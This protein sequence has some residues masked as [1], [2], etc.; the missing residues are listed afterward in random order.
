MSDRLL[1]EEACPA[2]QSLSW[3]IHAQAFA[4]EGMQ[5]WLDF[6][7]PYSVT[8]NIALARQK[9]YVLFESLPQGTDPVYVLELGAGPGFF[10]WHFLQAWQ[11]LAPDRPIHYLLTDFSRATLEGVAA[12]PAFQV[13]VETGCLGIFQLDTPRPE[14]LVA[15]S[16]VQFEIP[17][18]LHA[19]IGNYYACTLPTTLLCWQEERLQER[20]C[21]TWLHL[22]EGFPDLSPEQSQALKQW[23]LELAVSQKISAQALQNLH[24]IFSQESPDTLK[25]LTKW[26]EV[27]PF[28]LMNELDESSYYEPIQFSGL[29][30]KEIQLLLN[31]GQALREQSFPWPQGLWERLKQLENWLAPNALFFL[32]DKGYYLSSQSVP[33]DLSQPS[34]HGNTLAYPL[35]LDL[36]SDWLRLHGWQTAHT[37]YPFDPLQTLVAAWRPS[38]QNSW[39]ENFAAHFILQNNNLDAARLVRAAQDYQTQGDDQTAVG[40]YQKALRYRPGEPR[41]VHELT[42]CL[43]RLGAFRLAEEMLDIPVIDLY[44]QFDFDYQRGQI[45]FFLG[46]PAQAIESFQLSL[47]EQGEYASVYYSLALSYLALAQEAEAKDS[48]KNCLKLEPHHSAA[49]T[50][51]AKIQTP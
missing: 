48:L 12:R 41:I 42:A 34:L 35:H 1:L 11:E 46:E 45:A 19:I 7:I 28:E 5:A 49:Q 30:E 3:K 31:A 4:Q 47:I 43:I 44:Q 16:E 37:P 2:S 24:A 20:W 38:P 22:P 17:K 29:S 50:L 32:S 8:G 26:A 40:F 13:M 36:I 51:L 10:A 21:K 25:K 23:V 6:R 27:L 9:A 14:A 18:Q 33:A 39:R 15:I